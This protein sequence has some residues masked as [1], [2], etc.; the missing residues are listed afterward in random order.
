ME[1]K[2]IY[3]LFCAVSHILIFPFDWYTGLVH[4]CKAFGVEGAI[5]FPQQNYPYSSSGHNKN[6]CPIYI[7]YTL[8]HMPKK[9]SEIFGYKNSL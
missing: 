9:S 2:I 1:E 6:V 3:F 5:Q 8:C 4:W 7:H